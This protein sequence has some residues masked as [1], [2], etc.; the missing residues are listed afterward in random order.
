MNAPPVRVSSLQGL[1]LNEAIVG[2]GPPVVML[3][4]WG[5]N[6][7]LLWP[8]ASRLAPL[9]Y[10][11]YTL[12]LPGFGGTSLPPV[13]WGVA[14]YARWIAAYLD[15]HALERV[16]LFGHSFGGRLGLVLGADY[17]ERI[18]RMVLADSA[19]IRP[20]PPLHARLRSTLYRAARDAMTAAGLG[21]AADQLRARYAARYGSADFQ[22][23]QGV[24]R[25]TFIRVVTEDLRDYAARVRV[26]TL[27]LWG[28]Q[29]A[30][31]PLWQG[32][33]LE[34]LIPDAGLVVFQGAGHYSYL[35]KL[36]ETLQ[37]MDYFLK[38]P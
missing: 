37:V 2:D 17:P 27:L 19:G 36:A 10:R 31:T 22:A 1:T 8:L 7:S 29:D 24:L 32:Q 11:V 16:H 28:D 26:S 15:Q 18:H 13:A 4:G 9:G 6:L 3:H 35:D 21:N 34:K 5:A 14:D 23:T 30:D 38:Q 25:E 20:T 33:L 12:D